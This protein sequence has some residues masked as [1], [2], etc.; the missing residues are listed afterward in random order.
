LI[1]VIDINIGNVAS[2]ARALKHLGVEYRLSSSAEDI[3][4]AEKIIFP[5]VGSFSEAAKRL[6]ELGIRDVLRSRVAKDKIPILGIC[7]GMQL[8]ATTGD[9]GAQSQGLDLIKGRV[10]YHRAAQCGLKLPH[11]GWNEVRNSGGLRVF[12]SIPEESCF[13]FVHSFEF[14]PGEAVKI[15]V[16]DYGVDFA[17]AIQKEHIVGVQFHPEK[18]QKHGLRLLDNFSKGVM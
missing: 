14:I 1:T 13:Y 7:L 5:G 4:S 2:V 8:L 16:S 10:S 9:E 3:L 11:I 15:A 17:A 18:S 6:G 12:D